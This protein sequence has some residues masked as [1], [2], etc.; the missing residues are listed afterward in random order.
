[1]HQKHRISGNPPA[2]SPR[3]FFRRFGSDRRGAALAEFALIAPVLVVVI[4]GILELALV[5][6]V[7]VMMEAGVRD[8]SRF[9][10]TGAAAAGGASR[11]DRIAAIV[12][13]RTLGLVS[14]E[15]ITVD[16]RTYERFADIGLGEPFDDLDGDGA[17]DPG[18]T[19]DDLNG[20]G[21]HDADRGTPGAGGSEDIVL[22]EVTV[23]WGYITPMISAIIGDAAVLRAALAVRNEP[24]DTTGIGEAG[25]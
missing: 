25:S 22:Y 2:T 18:E 13:E 19:F 10:L 6:F 24:F 8:A 1:M 5:A 14:P 20:N 7:S 11:E 16:V 23:G 15:R 3:G 12:S 17:Y 9:G 21:A 4:F